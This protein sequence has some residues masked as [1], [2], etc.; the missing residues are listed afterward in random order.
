MFLKTH[1]LS[2]AIHTTCATARPCKCRVASKVLYG[3][4]RITLLEKKADTIRNLALS[5]QDPF[6]R[7]ELMDALAKVKEL[8]HEIESDPL[9]HNDFCKDAPWSMEC[10]TFD[11]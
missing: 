6:D 7:E 8:I 2:K 11:L 3:S 9:T 4:K 10:K 5:S 1:F